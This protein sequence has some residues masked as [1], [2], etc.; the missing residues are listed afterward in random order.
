MA[1]EE[2][3]SSYLDGEPID[4]E[5]KVR[6]KE[7]MANNPPFRDEYQATAFARD[8]V[9]ASR[10]AVRTATPADVRAAILASI[11]SEKTTTQISATP[12][13]PQAP[14]PVQ[15]PPEKQQLTKPEQRSSGGIFTLP[16]RYWLS[17]AVVVV[18][19]A[20]YFAADYL[21]EPESSSQ[22]RLVYVH[23]ANDNYRNQSYANFAAV[24]QGKVSFHMATSSY[25]ELENF[26]RKHGV[27]YDLIPPEMPAQLLGGVI[28]EH[29]GHKMAHLVFNYHDTLI[30]MFQAPR[31]AFSQHTVEVENEVLYIVDHGAWYWE[32][33]VGNGTLAIWEKG[34]TVCAIV[35]DMTPESL[36]SLLQHKG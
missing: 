13:E 17:A 33:N 23:P 30:Y 1:M 36:Q 27:H 7:Q 21:S 28:S 12:A 22:P 3:I 8:A 34:A 9:R 26:F 10:D 11:R 32:D 35:A 20:S 6:L 16:A 4:D 5:Q 29:Q 14:P 15:Q 25:Q 18:A 24:K 2:F 31:E 19:I